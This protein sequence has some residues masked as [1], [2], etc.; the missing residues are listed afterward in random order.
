MNVDPTHARHAGRRAAT[1]RPARCRAT[2]DF[3]LDII[4]D[5]FVGAFASGEILQVLLSRCCSASRCTG[6]ASAARRVLDL[7]ERV[8]HVLF[9]IVGDHHAARADRRVRRDGVHRSAST[10]SARSRSLGELMGC[11]YATCLLFVF[12]VLGTVARV[13]GFSIFKFIAL[14]Q[15]GAAHRARHVVVGVGA[16]ADDGEAG[17]P[18]RAQVGRSAWSIPTGYSFNLD[19][20]SIYL[21]MAAVFIAQATNTPLDA[22]RSSSTLLGGAAADLEGRGRR[23]RQ[24]LHRARGD[25]VGAS[26]TCRSPASR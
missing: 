9:G 7:I 3:L 13:H 17:E 2:V 22:R 4:P 6:S 1:P 26:A 16:A 14:H 23:D 8:G 11:F 21:T 24:R 20:T 18:R 5:T 25:A 12:V 10:A 19:G 15:G